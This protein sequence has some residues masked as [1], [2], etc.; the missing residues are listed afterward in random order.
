MKEIV[1]PK[2]GLTMEEGKINEWFKKEGDSVQKGEPI[3]EVESDKSTI[4][5]ESPWDGILH[6]ILVQEGETVPLTATIAY[7]R[8]PG[9]DEKYY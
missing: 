4:E 6:K 1:M 9:E 5:I 2:L 7:L 8:E 3:F